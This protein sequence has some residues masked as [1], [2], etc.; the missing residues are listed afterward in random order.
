MN[1][2]GAGKY[3]WG[4]VTLFAEDPVSAA[5]CVVLT[6]VVFAGK[7][8]FKIPRALVEWGTLWAAT[9]SVVHAGSHLSLAFHY[10]SKCT[11][12]VGKSANLGHRI[13][14][15]KRVYVFIYLE[16]GNEYSPNAKYINDK[17]RLTAL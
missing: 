4:G 6:N 8:M 7:G 17:L 10:A 9:M 16:H 14:I 1:F 13:F 15:T 11:T 3:W 2:S 5:V 12:N